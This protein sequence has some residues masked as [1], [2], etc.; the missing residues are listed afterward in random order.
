VSYELYW[1]IG[2]FRKP[3]YLWGDHQFFETS[4]FPE[5]LYYLSTNQTSFLL[6][7]P[8]RVY[9][10]HEYKPE[11]KL[12]LGPLGKYEIEKGT[13]VFVEGFK[14][15]W[16][17]GDSFSPIREDLNVV[18]RLVLPGR[19]NAVDVLCGVD[20]FARIMETQR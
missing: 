2:L 3:D 9:P 13:S 16:G 6:H 11:E 14:S 12:T 8:I 1:L 18:L 15:L 4:R 5:R 7:S 19:T 17:G 20:D 10:I